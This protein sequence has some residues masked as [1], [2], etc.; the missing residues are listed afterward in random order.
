M[1]LEKYGPWGLII[2]G[3]EGIGAAFA[4]K[5]ATQ[6]FNVV[7]I[8]RKTQPLE[9]LASELRLTGIQVRTLSADLSKPDV[10]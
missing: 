1:N 9:E 5:L 10:L 4:R 3:S 6:K 7:L 2:G 8:A